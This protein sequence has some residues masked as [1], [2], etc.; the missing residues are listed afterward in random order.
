MQATPSGRTSSKAT[1]SSDR[2]DASKGNEWKAAAR[3]E[4]QRVPSSVFVTSSARGRP[5][6]PRQ[7]TNVEESSQSQP[8]TKD[9][10]AKTEAAG[11][12]TNS[13]SSRD[14]V[15]DE[16]G[17]EDGEV[18][19]DVK[20]LESQIRKARTEARGKAPS[21]INSQLSLR[22]REG[23]KKELGEVMNERASARSARKLRK[24]NDK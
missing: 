21:I 17:D 22:V 4:A 13:K 11:R 6:T 14:F 24:I 7:D 20:Q 2:S 16:D 10:R 19:I 15:K 3:G 12:Q 5:S 23:L 8:G 9:R 1:A 18:N